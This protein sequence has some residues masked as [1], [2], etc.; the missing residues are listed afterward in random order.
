[1]HGSNRICPN[2]GAEISGLHSR[3]PKPKWYGSSTVR[4]CAACGKH[5][6]YDGASKRWLLLN[7][8]LSVP[9]FWPGEPPKILIWLCVAIASLGDLM[10]LATRKIIV[11]ENRNA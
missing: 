7:L 1:M 11:K 3:V 4:G 5:L 2:C 8:V 6:S 10:F 9:L